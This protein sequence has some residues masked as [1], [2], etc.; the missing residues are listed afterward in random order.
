[1]NKVNPNYALMPGSYLFAEVGRRVSAFQAA[2]PE[3]KI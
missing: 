3:K 1:M 2:H